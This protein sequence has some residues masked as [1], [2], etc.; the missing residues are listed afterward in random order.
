MLGV[1]VAILPALGFPSWFRTI[2]YIMS[3]LSIATLAY[4]SSVVYC[5]N[6]KKLIEDAEQIFDTK[7]AVPTENAPQGK[8]PGQDITPPPTK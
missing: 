2:L 3:G 4:L 1:L 7:A 5:S 8:T 6:C